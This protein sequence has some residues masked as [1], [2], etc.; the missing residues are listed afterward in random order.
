MQARV[1]RLPLATLAVLLP[2]IIASLWPEFG[3]L[4][5]YERHRIVSGD[6]WR[7]ITGNWIHFSKTHFAYDVL[8]FA[9]AGSLLE[10][11]RHRGFGWFCLL[12][13]IVIGLAVFLAEPELQLFGG[14]SGMATGA[15][16]L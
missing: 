3:S 1:T 16:V 6:L 12:S 10:L 4:L 9:M 14:L 5:M 11:R 2:A 8:A 13:P 15:M 7:V